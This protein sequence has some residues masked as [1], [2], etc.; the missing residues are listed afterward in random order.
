MWLEMFRKIEK[1]L[2]NKVF[3]LKDSSFFS[4]IIYVNNIELAEGK[5]NKI[6]NTQNIIKFPFISAISTKIKS[7]N[8]LKIAGVG[9]V[10]FITEDMKVCSQ[11]YKSKTFMNYSSFIEKVQGV[12]KH[13]CVVI[14]TGVFPHIDFLLGRNRIV[15][16]VDLIN[17][18]NEMYDDN[19]HG[20]FVTG[21]LSANSITSVYSG[22]DK[23][24]DVIVIKA[25]DENG[26]TSS[27]KIL[28]AMQWVIDNK[29]NYNIK[30]V[31]MSFGSIFQ[32]LSD[33]LIR[34][35]E[36]LWDN[37]IVVVSAAGNSGP[38][39]ETIMSPGASKKVITVGS[40]NN[41]DI[42]P[43][44][45]A[46]FSSR[47]PVFNY[48]KPDLLT[49]GVDIVSNNVFGKEKKFYTIMS[50]TSVSTPMV[51][52]IISLILTM[53]ENYTPNQIKY[54]LSNSCVKIRGDRNSEG[55]GYLDMNKIIIN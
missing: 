40:L 24:L 11:I 35:A 28:E 21:V 53:N 17:Y 43:L 42:K 22:M 6:L 52:G 34:G 12:A 51:A 10:K 13:T 46:D 48:F 8:L 3:T 2:L 26:E 20:T 49:P 15:K 54:I 30:I 1:S 55:F 50:G 41:I 37:G 39:S 14:D 19:G 16:F 25:L 7:S 36:I 5:L 29:E 9:D 44:E 32:S 45:V 27:V 33:P 4:V 23:S 38:E 31:C 47:G 18:R